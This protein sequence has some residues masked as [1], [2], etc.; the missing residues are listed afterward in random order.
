MSR[1][2]IKAVQK[3][4][5]EQLTAAVAAEKSKSIFTCGGKIPITGPVS[6]AKPTDSVGTKAD[7]LNDTVDAVNAVSQPND[8]HSGARTTTSA[9]PTIRFGP[10][11]TGS[12][13]TFPPTPDDDTFKKLLAACDPATFGVGGTEVHDEAYRKASKL[14]ATQLCTDFCPYSTG[15]V[16]II[17]QLLIPSVG[18]HRSVRVEFYKLNIYS[19]PSDHFKAHVDTPRSETQIGSLVVALPSA[20]EGDVFHPLHGDFPTDCNC[21]RRA[22]GP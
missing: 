16:D 12:V 1:E 4:Y 9:P 7:S 22:H 19:G 14:D 5:V 20:F 8:V 2:S 15:M 3:Q 18:A 6:L 17:N 11:G 10:N 13:L 21:R